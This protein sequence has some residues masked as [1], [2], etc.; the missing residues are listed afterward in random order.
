M[1]VFVDLWKLQDGIRSMGSDLR[2][3]EASSY[4]RP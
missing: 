1:I 2:A 4:E 3:L